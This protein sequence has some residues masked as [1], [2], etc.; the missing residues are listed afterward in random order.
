MLSGR[1]NHGGLLVAETAWQRG[2]AKVYGGSVDVDG[3]N[4]HGGF[5]AAAVAVVHSQ[6]V[7]LLLLG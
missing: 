3:V 5:V 2:G 6:L 7:W 4:A 1:A